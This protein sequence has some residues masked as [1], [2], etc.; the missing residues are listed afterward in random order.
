MTLMHWIVVGQHQQS[1]ASEGN[2]RYYGKTKQGA[3]MCEGAATKA[4]Y[5]IAKNEQ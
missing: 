1:R 3:Y 4:G 5:H 2:T